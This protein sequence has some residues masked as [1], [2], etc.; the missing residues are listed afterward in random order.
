MFRQWIR[1]QGF[2]IADKLKKSR[3]SKHYSDIKKIIENPELAESLNKKRLQLI[4][5]N[6]VSNTEF[7]EKYKGF[8]SLQDFPV[9]DKN[10]LRSNYNS[11]KS[12]D[13][14]EEEL[15]KMTTSGSTGSPFTIYQPIEKHYRVQ[16]EL[17]YFS[18]WAD[19]KVGT[20]HMFAHVVASQNRKSKL[21]LWMQNEVDFDVSDQ[22]DRALEKQCN[23]LMKDKKIKIIIGYASAVYS[24]AEFAIKKGYNPSLFGLEGIITASEPLYDDMRKTIIEAFGCK[25]LQRYSNMENGVLGHE[26]VEHKEFHINRASYI[27]ELLS[28]E[29]DLPVDE[30]EIGRIVVTDLFNTAMP[31]I[32]YDTGDIGIMQNESKC[33]I[34][35]P[36]LTRLDG[37][38]VDNIY[39]T[40]GEMISPHAITNGFWKYSNVLKQFQFIQEDINR[41]KIILNV[42]DN[43][44]HESI[45]LSTIKSIVG[46]NSIVEVEY[47]NEIPVLNSGKRKYI[48]CNYKK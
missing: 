29:S 28:L 16:A 23:I 2:C 32:R 5:N 14:K 25:V 41:Y 44:N 46:D 3:V 47:R 27:V 9:V 19:Y 45:I 38:R 4:L 36:V 17:I 37:R 15:W 21:K 1:E 42:M 30:G 13:F 33:N 10:I 8:C 34:K 31:M 40:R 26:C 24:L 11:I 20:K 12:K 22:S 35:T 18:Q 7:Y 39:N 43:F 48:V 6:A